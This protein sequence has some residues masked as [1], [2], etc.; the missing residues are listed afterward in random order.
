MTRFFSAPSLTAIFIC[1]SLSAMS[2]KV[3]AVTL[4]VSEN[5]IV[6]EVNDQDVDNGF[7][8]KQKSTFKLD[9]GNHAIIVKYKDVFEDL[10][11]AEDRVVESQEFVV[12]FKITNQQQLKLSTTKIKNLASA[13]AF[14]KSP[15][16]NLTDRSHNQLPLSLEKVEDYKLAKQVDAAVNTLATKQRIQNQTATLATT[17]PVTTATT[18]KMAKSKVNNT[19]IQINSLTMLTYWWQ[20]ASNDEKQRFKQLIKEN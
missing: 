3:E 11:F 8:G 9:K 7:I 1:C 5:L 6:S 4:K 13:E 14:A 16:L 12:K 15:Q 17:A 19:S 10:D 2:T 18:V 20:N